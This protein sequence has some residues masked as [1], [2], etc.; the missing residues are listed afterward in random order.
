MFYIRRFSAALAA[1]AFLCVALGAQAQTWFG[2]ERGLHRFNTQ[3]GAVDVDLAFGEAVSVV[4]DRDDGS[5][6]VLSKTRIAHFSSDGQVV[7][8]RS[9]ASYPGSFGNARKMAVNPADATV[10]IAD[11]RRILHV[12]GGGGEFLSVIAGEATDL[13][14]AQDGTLWVLDENAD[15]LR[16]YTSGGSLLQR[17][18]L[19][20]ASR[21]AHHLAIDSLRGVAWFVADR[22]LV[23]RSFKTPG[24][25]LARVNVAHDA[26]ATC[27]DIETGDLWV[28]GS[29]VLYGYRSDGS[30]FATRDL[31]V[32]GIANAK[33]LACDHASRSLW[34]GHR[35]GFSQFTRDGDR[36]LTQR[37]RDSDWVAV[38]REVM[39]IRLAL[40]FLAGSDTPT[41]SQ[42][43]FRFRPSLSCGVEDCA[44]DPSTLE[45]TLSYAATLDGVEVGGQ[46][47][48]DSATGEVWFQ[49]AATLADGTHTLIVR[50]VDGSGNRSEPQ[51]VTFDVDA[52]PPALVSVTPPSGTRLPLGTT[53]VSVDAT[54]DASATSVFADGKP[55][56]AGNRFRS[57]FAIPRGASMFSVTLHALDQ[58]GNEASVLVAYTIEQ[59]NV[60]PTLQLLQPAHNQVFEA[61]A[62]I[63][64]EATAT[65]VDGTIDRVVFA[66]GD[67]Q[68]V[69]TS[70]PY[71]AVFTGLPIGQ[72]PVTAAAFD[73]KGAIAG[74]GVTVTVAG[75]PKVVVTTP[76]PGAEVF[77]GTPVAVTFEP[78]PTRT[79]Q[80]LTVLRDGQNP[81]TVSNPGAAYTYIPTG[82]GVHTFRFVATDSAGVQGTGEITLTLKPFTLVV[83]TPVANSEV[84]V[85]TVKVEGRYFGPPD[86]AI[87]VNGFPAIVTPTGPD[88]GTFR[89]GFVPLEMGPRV[90][91]L[92][93][94]SPSLSI[95]RGYSVPITVVGIVI[96]PPDPPVPPVGGGGSGGG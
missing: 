89:L 85:G 45:S 27:S 56:Q 91:E 68:A 69:V 78:S 21:R 93:L 26:D 14:V 34:V 72:Y 3:S 30:N 25:V 32:D 36:L 10:W 11:D 73:N 95:G 39:Q 16:R 19:G 18:N 12:N 90:I 58:W 7:F 92:E 96:V 8:S 2:D 44:F 17:L 5:V 28:L 79:I 33:S 84:T 38:A 24:Q 47:T 55:A 66:L 61:P 51:T 31:H 81:F 13:A 88:G 20:G 65:D 1:L 87:L 75:P 6:W 4:T 53:Q 63:T 35:R 46:F 76:A 48:F 80:S 41:D 15:E 67:R 71:R 49:P 43:L 52:T 70:P 23:K 64:V 60:P 86:T 94:S 9:L 29:N 59:P 82:S 74:F 57:T 42:P 40:E 50:V 83:D 22:A 62:D 77:E 37:A 54:F